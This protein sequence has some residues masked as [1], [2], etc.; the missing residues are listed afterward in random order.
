[1]A[2]KAGSKWAKEHQER[3]TGDV[4]FEWRW[5]PNVAVAYNLEGAR[6]CRTEE[7][8]QQRISVVSSGS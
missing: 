1:M 4:I 8:F 2:L 3:I 7:E 6:I 5:Q